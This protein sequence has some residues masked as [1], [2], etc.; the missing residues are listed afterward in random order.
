MFLNSGRQLNI[1][2]TSGHVCCY[3]NCP[4]LS[5]LFY[6]ITLTGVL[7]GI[8]YIMRNSSPLK[9]AAHSLRNIHAGCTYQYRLTFLMIFTD[10]IYGSFKLFT[11]G[12][13]NQIFFI[14][15]LDR[16]IGRNYHHIQL[17]NLVE[18][19]LF[20][21]G[22]TRHPRKFVIHPEIVLQRDS[23]VRLGRGLY[24]NLLFR[25]NSL[26]KAIRITATGKHPPRMFI[27]NLYFA[28]LNDVF[29]FP[30]KKCICF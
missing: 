20:R 2:T 17:I 30:L 3:G 18:F 8:Q 29:F 11:L 13:E 10:L 26:V 7:L 4:D 28:V 21:F 22:C 14:I 1:R 19:T 15:P 25:L 24:F 12:F 5:G 23:C 9:H 16:A 6:N 27:Y